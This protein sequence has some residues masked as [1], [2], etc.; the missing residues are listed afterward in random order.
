MGSL[1]LYDKKPLHWPGAPSIL[2]KA[3]ENTMTISYRDYLGQVVA[4]LPPEQK[5][6]YEAE[7]VW[8][9]MQETVLG[10]LD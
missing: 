6:D 4:Y 10:A 8:T 1:Q 5:A 3:A 2:T 7:S 9:Q